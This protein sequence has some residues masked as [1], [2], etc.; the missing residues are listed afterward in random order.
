MKDHALA[1]V[2]L[3]DSEGDLIQDSLAANKDGEH[4]SG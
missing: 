2:S 4:R 1:V 3:G